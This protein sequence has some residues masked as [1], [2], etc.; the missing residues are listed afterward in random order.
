MYKNYDYGR[1]P[2]VGSH[3]SV[4]MIYVYYH[5]LYFYVFMYEC[6]MQTNQIS[7]EYWNIG[8]LDYSILFYSILFYSILFYSILFYSILFYSILFYSILFY[9]ILFYSILFYSILFYS[10]LFYSILFYSILFYSILFYSILF[11]SISSCLS[12]H[13]P[14]MQLLVFL[15]PAWVALFLWVM[16]QHP[17]PHQRVLQGRNQNHYGFTVHWDFNIYLINLCIF[18]STILFICLCGHLIC[19]T[20]ILLWAVTHERKFVTWMMIVMMIAI[21]ISDL[22]HERKLVTWM[23]I[24]M[25]IAMR[26]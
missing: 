19:S 23:I 4:M 15:L 25:L 10:I 9:S 24:A 5:S 7:M 3:L 14:E 8:I 11:Y 21:R 18:L 13:K 12:W 6:D 22:T 26:L 2:D 16:N 20:S 17:W 1:V